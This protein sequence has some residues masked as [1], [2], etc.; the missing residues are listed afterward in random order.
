M[1]A[2]RAFKRRDALL[3]ISPEPIKAHPAKG[4]TIIS[5]RKEKTVRLLAPNIQLI[6]S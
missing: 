1:T 6:N 3:R 5:V 2:T 4:I